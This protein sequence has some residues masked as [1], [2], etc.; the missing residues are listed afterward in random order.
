MDDEDDPDE[1]L[2][3]D[4]SDDELRDIFAYLSI[5]DD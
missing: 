2:L 5:V 3:D 4:F 1:E